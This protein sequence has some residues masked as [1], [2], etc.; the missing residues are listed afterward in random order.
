MQYQQEMAQM[1]SQSLPSIQIEYDTSSSSRSGDN[2]QSLVTQANSV[3]NL[4]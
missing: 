1:V 2:P 3:K 4:L